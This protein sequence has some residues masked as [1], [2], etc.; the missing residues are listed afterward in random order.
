MT[1]GRPP[2]PDR[3]R[4]GRPLPGVAFRDRLRQRLAQAEGAASERVYVL[5]AGAT[6]AGVLLLLVGVVIGR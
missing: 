5:I 6:A 3:L 4:A 2:L 1:G